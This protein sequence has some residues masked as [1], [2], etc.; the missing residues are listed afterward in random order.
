MNGLLIRNV[1]RLDN[2][3]AMASWLGGV[4]PP[5]HDALPELDAL[6]R[7]KRSYLVEGDVPISVMNSLI[8]GSKQSPGD[9]RRTGAYKEG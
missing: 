5:S 6:F 8:T 4:S 9:K 3:P 7:E 1:N 2:L